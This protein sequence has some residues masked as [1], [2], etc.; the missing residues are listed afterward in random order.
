MTDPDQLKQRLAAMQG[1]WQEAQADAPSYGG[2]QPPDGTYQALVNGFDTFES[3]A[4]E[5][6]L[7]I[8]LQIADGSEWNGHVQE[9][10]GSLEDPQR[11][12]YTKQDLATLGVNVDEVDLS[13]LLDSLEP[14]LDVPVEIAIKR[15]DRT[16]NQ[17]EHFVNT[18][19]NKRLGDPLPRTDVPA[20]APEPA[21]VGNTDDCPF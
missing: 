6:F 7:K 3:K 14:V 9:K 20:E 12:A 4:G 10:V 19:I 18:Y 13:S 17:G 15:S 8:K 2:P 5:L 11:I 16:N 21:Q 1:A